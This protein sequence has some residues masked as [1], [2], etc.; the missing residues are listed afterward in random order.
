[1]GKRNVCLWL[2]TGAVFLLFPLIAVADESKCVA[3]HKEITPSIVKDFMSGAMGKSGMDCSDCHGADHMTAEDAAKVQLPTEK[4]CQKCHE[5]QAAQYMDGKHSLAWIAMAAMPETGFQPHAY[6]QGM[7]GC[8]GCHKVGVRDEATKAESKY[9][10]PC[11]SCHTRH[12]F[13]KEE[14]RKPEAC[15]TCHMG[16][17]HP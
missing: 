15:R 10:S 3:C 9:G 11:D 8:G 14:A 13:S 4:T 17:D 16:F 7:K 5:E 2:M 6:I 12:K 1:M